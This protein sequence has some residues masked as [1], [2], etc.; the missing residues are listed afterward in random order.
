[1]SAGEIVDSINKV[2]YL[3][4]TDPGV[5]P[6]NC[7]QGLLPGVAPKQSVYIFPQPQSVY[8]LTANILIALAALQIYNTEIC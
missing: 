3:H 8:I 2:I 5:V 4:R 6:N 1:M 7:I